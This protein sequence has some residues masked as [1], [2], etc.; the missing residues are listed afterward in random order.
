VI[1]RTAGM[2]ARRSL[3]AM[4]PSNSTAPADGTSRSPLLAS[5]VSVVA[6]LGID[7]AAS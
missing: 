3:T 6:V 7:S 1:R 2:S 4:T 5:P